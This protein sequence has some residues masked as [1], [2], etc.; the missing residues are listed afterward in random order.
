[1]R[2]SLEHEVRQSLWLLLLTFAAC[3]VL[4]AAAVWVSG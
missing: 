1:M 3:A 4:G 2:G